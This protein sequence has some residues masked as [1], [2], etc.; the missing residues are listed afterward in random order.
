MPTLTGTAFTA[1]KATDDEVL[2]HG[3]FDPLLVRLGLVWSIVHSCPTDGERYLVGFAQ[4]HP[5]RL[6]EALEA[7][8]GDRSH[9]ELRGDAAFGSTMRA[10]GGR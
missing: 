5:I 1:E 8:F 6:I 2:R 4:G 3:P 9:D 7:E 10:L